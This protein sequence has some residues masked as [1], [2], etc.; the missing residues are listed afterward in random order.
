MT[1]QHN[2]NTTKLSMLKTK[3]MV[4]NNAT[5]VKVHP[6]LFLQYI[7]RFITYHF[8]LP[9][10][11]F[12]ISCSR[13]EHLTQGQVLTCFHLRD[14]QVYFC[15]ATFDY[16]IILLPVITNINKGIIYFNGF[17]QFLYILFIILFAS[18]IKPFLLIRVEKKLTSQQT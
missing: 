3:N 2:I 15:L 14:L 4:K 6:S 9:T 13:P 5:N 16:Q 8:C 1:S 10:N 12:S 7:F 18:N 17:I 11:S